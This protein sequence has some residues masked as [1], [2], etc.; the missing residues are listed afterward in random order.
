MVDIR[1]IGDS[2]YVLRGE[3]NVLMNRRFRKGHTS[4][5]F[6]ESALPLTENVGGVGIN[7]FTNNEWKG[8]DLDSLMKIKILSL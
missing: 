4:H 1:H 2:F 3:I 6:W 8:N 5:G 7:A